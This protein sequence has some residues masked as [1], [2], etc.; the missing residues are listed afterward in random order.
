MS[1]RPSNHG[2]Q[3][4]NQTREMVAN[5]SEHTKTIKQSKLK[6]ASTRPTQLHL[7]LLQDIRNCAGQWER[8]NSGQVVDAQSVGN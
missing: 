4:E 7:F 8:R 3:S 6:H 1:T 2:L 5:K